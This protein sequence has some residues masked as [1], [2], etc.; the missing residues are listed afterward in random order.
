MKKVT[1][2]VA[3]GALAVVLVAAGAAVARS[4]ATTIQ[5]ATA[6][7]AADEVPAPTGN[8]AGARGSFTAT[9]TRSGA[10][11]PAATS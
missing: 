3:S 11:L 5:I 7:T 2:V 10:G 8:V 9:V 1:L 4:E 6:L